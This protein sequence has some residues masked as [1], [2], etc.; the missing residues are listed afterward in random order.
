LNLGD[1]KEYVSFN[2]SIDFILLIDP[3]KILSVE[4]FEFFKIKQRNILNNISEGCLHQ[5]VKNLLL[6]VKILRQY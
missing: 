3:V 5:L 6:N 1:N 2:S 4:Y